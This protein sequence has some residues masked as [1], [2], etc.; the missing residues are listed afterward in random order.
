[1]NSE[2]TKSTSAWLE[3]INDSVLLTDTSDRRYSEKLLLSILVEL[4]SLNYK[5][6]KLEKSR[7]GTRH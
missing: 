5:L 1:M 3:K 7:N 6:Y 4:K 2:T